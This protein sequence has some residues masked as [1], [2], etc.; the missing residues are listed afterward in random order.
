MSE[1]KILSIDV[2]MDEPMYLAVKGLAEVDGVS[3]PELIRM[4]VSTM[5]DERRAYY[6]A[7]ENIFGDGAATSNQKRTAAPLESVDSKSSAGRK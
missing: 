4:L 6:A 7:L 5:I 2:A 1:K 3:A